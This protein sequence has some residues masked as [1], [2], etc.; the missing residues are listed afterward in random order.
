MNYSIFDDVFKL[1]YRIQFYNTVSTLPYYIGWPDRLDAYAK[2]F[3]YLHSPI[4]SENIISSGFFENIMNDEINSFLHNKEIIHP[5][6]NLTHPSNV[7]FPHTHPMHQ[8]L[9]YYVNIEWQQHWH[10]ET[11]IYKENAVDIETAVS[12]IPNRI[13]LLDK[14]VPHAI[15][16]PSIA[17][18]DYR[19]TFACFLK[20]KT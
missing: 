2:S 14:G 18:P 19:Y 3:T 12:F 1:D 20:D 9:V 6:I 11:I 4:T 8:A 7:F 16:P 13:L 10:G 17:C 15:R 5:V